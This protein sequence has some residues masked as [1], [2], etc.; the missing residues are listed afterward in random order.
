MGDIPAMATTRAMQIQELV[1][2]WSF[3]Q[4][5]SEEWLPV[6]KVPTNVHLDLLDNKKYSLSRLVNIGTELILMGQNRRPVPRLQRTE[7]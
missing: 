4:T 5:D 3:K 7:V 6:K 1:T 2:G